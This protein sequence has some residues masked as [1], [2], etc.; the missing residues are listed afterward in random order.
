MSDNQRK[1][2][3][4]LIKDKRPITE[5]HHGDCIGS[6]Y[7]AH[8][9]LRQVSESVVV[10]YPPD[11]TTKRAYCIGEV[12]K[13]PKPYLER[14]KDIVNNTDLLIACPKSDKEELRSGTWA[15]I[16]YARKQNKEVIMIRR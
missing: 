14:N 12:E 3:K 1:L 9:L 15:T 4:E 2:F 5:F 16:R 10:L 13:E 11:I 8:I 6:D 7:D